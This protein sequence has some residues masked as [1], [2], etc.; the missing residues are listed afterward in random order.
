MTQAEIYSQLTEV[1]REVFD[2]DALEIGPTT[3]AE[4]IHGWDSQAHITLIVA[5]EAH[6]GIRFR[7]SE[8][9]GLKNVDE[10]VQVIARK[11]EAA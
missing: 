7:T 4:D 2:D 10:L 3:T 11:C 5:T 9:E 6:F 8:L 1:M